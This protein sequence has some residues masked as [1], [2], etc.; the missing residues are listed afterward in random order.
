MSLRENLLTTSTPNT[1]NELVELNQKEEWTP[2][3]IRDIIM[4]ELDYTQEDN[5][6]YH[7]LQRQLNFHEFLLKKCL[8][9]KDN[10]LNPISLVEQV[11]KLQVICELYKQV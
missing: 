7:L 10:N 4:D 3:K 2:E 9:E 6:I 8:S 11:T 5:L 1:P